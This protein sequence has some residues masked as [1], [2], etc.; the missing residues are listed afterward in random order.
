MPYIGE[1]C[2]PFLGKYMMDITYK[3]T[4]LGSFVS[5][6]VDPFYVMDMGR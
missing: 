6:E 2:Y 5:N 1:I 4:A 3:N